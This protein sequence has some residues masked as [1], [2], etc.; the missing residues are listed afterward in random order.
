MR[1]EPHLLHAIIFFNSSKSRMH[2]ELAL[3]HISFG[4][5]RNSGGGQRSPL[6]L[7]MFTTNSHQ[8]SLCLQASCS[9]TVARWTRKARTT[10]HIEF[11]VSQQQWKNGGP[12][13]V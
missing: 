6:C 4:A 11:H 10:E 8:F 13:R 3:G 2:L 9:L 7:R 5:R 1:M 12:V